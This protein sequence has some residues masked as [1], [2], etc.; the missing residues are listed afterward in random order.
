MGTLNSTVSNDA[1][2][3]SAIDPIAEQAAEWIMLLTADDIAERTRARQ[4]YEVWKLADPRHAA[5]AAGMEG[6]INKVQAVRAPMHGDTRPARAA[7]NAAFAPERKRS[8]SKRL[9]VVLAITLALV[10]PASLL[11]HIWSPS[12]LMADLHTATGS[13]ETRTLSDG[14][15]ITL[16]SASA[17]NLHYDEQ[18]RAIELIQGEILVDV[19]KDAVRPFLVETRDGS[20]RALG[21]RF[22]VNQQNDATIL[23]MLES[24]VSVQTATQRAA[25]LQDATQVHAGQRVRITSHSID[26]AEDID[27]RSVSDAWKFHQLV[28]NDRPL[29]EVLDALSRQR[30]GHIQYDPAQLGDIRVSAVLPMDDTDR[31][32]QLLRTNFPQLR[33]RLVTPFLVLVD[34]QPSQ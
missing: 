32:L 21:T 1:D 6:F 17:V 15:R 4:D 7:L 23:T 11:L 19:A 28:V 33:I 2:A 12:Y 20:I 14:T 16:N 30:P 26:S 31:A 25:K 9:G 18:R 29:T 10:L 5:A 3:S 34:T 24:K 27:V 13:W 8:R 22:V